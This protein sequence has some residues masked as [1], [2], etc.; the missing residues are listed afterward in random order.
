[1][2]LVIYSQGGREESMMPSLVDICLVFQ[3]PSSYSVLPRFGKLPLFKFFFPRMMVRSLLSQYP[4]QTV[5]DLGWASHLRK[6]ERIIW[7]RMEKEVHGVSLG[8]G[9]S[10]TNGTDREQR[11]EN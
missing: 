2:V 9:P 7:K 6:H 3:L 10:V 4:L 5:C 8:T 11:E 1:M